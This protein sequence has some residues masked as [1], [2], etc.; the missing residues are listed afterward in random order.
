M[1]SPK[2]EYTTTPGAC[3]ITEEGVQ[4]PEGEE[5]D[6]ETLSFGHDMAIASM[7]SLKLFVTCTIDEDALNTSMKLSKHTKK[8]F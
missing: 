3:N 8:V 2:V 6:C 1:L 4:E 5:E 7:N